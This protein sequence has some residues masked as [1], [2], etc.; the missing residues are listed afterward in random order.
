MKNTNMGS[1]CHKI[2]NFIFFNNKQIKSKLWGIKLYHYSL[3]LTP[4]PHQYFPKKTPQ[5]RDF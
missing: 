5:P 3:S 2:G 4:V 1:T